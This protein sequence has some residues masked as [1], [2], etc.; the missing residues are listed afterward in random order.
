MRSI[1]NGQVAFGLVSIG[2]RMYSAT[3]SGGVRLRQVHAEDGG[4]IRYRRVCSV[5]GEE[6]PYE[7]IAKGY[8]TDGGEMVVLTADDLE[9]A[10]TPSSKTAEVVEFVPLESIDPVYFDKTYY[11]EP[12]KSAVKPYLLLRDALHKSGRVAIARVALRGREALAVL[13]VVSDVIVL[14][15]LLWAD[16]VR[17]PD[18]PFLHEDTP[19]V[20][21]K[22]MDMAHSLID[23]MSEDVFDPGEFHDGYREA[24]ERL[25]DAKIQGHDTVTPAESDGAAREAD[26]GD[27]SDLLRALSASVEQAGSR[28]GDGE[29]APAK[30]TAKKSAPKKAASTTT[31]TKKSAGGKSGSAKSGTAA[32]TKKTAAK[33]STAKKTAAKKTPAKKSAA[34]K[35]PA[36]K[37][38]AEKA[39]ARKASA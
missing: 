3:E 14:N 11:L 32:A 24:V 19:S 34:R 29:A 10:A 35:S 38:T 37:S 18:F 4:R 15:T 22:E 17:S 9:Q 27:V 5:D 28:G 6:V 23:S 31:A 25:V 8:E 26:E 39:G 13:R 36:Q 30:K 33:E 21:A 2:V 7:E 20:R 1:W 12:Q 16:E